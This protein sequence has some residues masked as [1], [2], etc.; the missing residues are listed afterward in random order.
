MANTVILDLGNVVL[1]IDFR[2]VFNYW[3]EASGAEVQRFHDRWEMCE[4]YSAH[5]TGELDFPGYAEVL[6]DRFDVAL[7]VEDWHQGW[8]S[9]WLK[10]FNEVV[11]LLPA[12]KE[13]YQLYAFSNTNPTHEAYFREHFADALDPFHEV[14]TS[15]GL[16]YRKPHAKSFSQLCRHI[17]V[18][19]EQAIFVDDSLENITGAKAAGLHAHHRQGGVEV[20]ELLAELL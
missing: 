10:P 17:G 3:A 1:G 11:E 9:L 18:A 2:R 16:G 7:S 4:A 15:S 5:E 6:A 8:N 12:L 13:R 14:Y 20:A 19:P